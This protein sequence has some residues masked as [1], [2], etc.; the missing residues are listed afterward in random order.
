MPTALPPDHGDS[1]RGGRR[2]KSFGALKRRVAALRPHAGDVSFAQ[3]VP[4]KTTGLGEAGEP[5]NN[6]AGSQRVG[7]RG[8]RAP[9]PGFTLQGVKTRP[10]HLGHNQPSV[11]WGPPWITAGGPRLFHPWETSMP[12][13]CPQPALPVPRSGILC[14]PLGGWAGGRMLFSGLEETEKLSSLPDFSR[15]IFCF[16]LTVRRNPRLRPRAPPSAAP[17]GACQHPRKKKANANQPGREKHPPFF[18]R[19]NKE[20]GENK[21]RQNTGLCTGSQRSFPPLVECLTAFNP[22]ESCG[23]RWDR[24]SPSLASAPFQGRRL[25]KSSPQTPLQSS[26]MEGD[27]SPCVPPGEWGGADE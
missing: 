8:P 17:R 22:L 21:W 25:Q 6:P 24:N 12:F 27:T 3:F 9:A 4:S 5:R 19:E 1:E 15:A 26:Q 23:Q 2:S 18:Q 14:L 20:A 10:G 7:G 16:P 11:P 13:P